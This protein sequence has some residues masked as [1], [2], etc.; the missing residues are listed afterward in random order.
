MIFSFGYRD[1][2]D[3][4]E[5]H[6]YKHEACRRCALLIC[7]FMHIKLILIKANRHHGILLKTC[8]FYGFHKV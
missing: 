8:K 5:D 7:S 1:E 3:W 4:N 6:S 2:H